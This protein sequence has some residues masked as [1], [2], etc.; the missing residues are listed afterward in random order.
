M[1]II[2]AHTTSVNY[3]RVKK[4]LD[5]FDS[6]GDEIIYYGAQREGQEQDKLQEINKNFNNVKVSYYN[7]TI[8]HGIRSVFAFFGYIINL[9][10][11]IKIE[12]P[13]YIIITNEELYLAL[14]FGI[15]KSKI[16]LDAI[17]AIDIRV[18]VNSV[19][20]GILYTF[21]KFV[22]NKVDSVVEVEEFRKNRFPIYANKTIVIRNTPNVFKFENIENNFGNYIYASGSLNQDINGIEQL[23]DAIEL[24]NKN[25]KNPIQLLIAGIIKGEELLQKIKSKSFVKLLGYLS[26]KNSYMYA[27]NSIA[28][29][30]FYRPDRLNFINAAPNK[31]Y[32]S[33]ML[34][35]PILINKECLISELCINKGNGFQS[36]YYD[37]I[38]L[39]KKI[40]EI[41]E[42]DLNK[43]EYLKYDFQNNDSWDIEKVKW[44][45]IIN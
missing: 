35:K 12:K 2:Y 4:N 17:D 1:K 26:L 18:N 22:R 44:S 15:G 37:H 25:S 5:F 23:I 38:K 20:R 9:N 8:P 7:K 6:M 14:L 31:V 39:A 11:L 28:M 13:D 43:F 41:L 27:S 24:V 10:R 29:F 21:V 42:L 36:I 19:F 30:A 16:I 32:E 33:F 40:Q 3:V 34:G 45:Q